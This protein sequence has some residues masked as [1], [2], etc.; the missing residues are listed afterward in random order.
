VS[1]HNII[2]NLLIL[3]SFILALMAFLKGHK[4]FLQLTILLGITS[5]EE[6]ISLYLIAKEIDFTW[7][8]HVYNIIEYSLLCLFFLHYIKNKVIKKLISVS[9]PV[10]ICISVSISFFTYKFE[11]FP[12]L[13][14][15]IEGLLLSVVCVYMLLN[16]E[17]EDNQ[18][19][20]KKHIFWI[21][22][23]IFVFFGS[24]FFYNG[25]YTRI[26]NIDP[27]KAMVLFSIINRPLNL[28]LYSFII[29]G[30]TC[31]LTSKKPII[32]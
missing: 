9:I 22:S 32:Q 21:C 25:I 7:L 31:L 24:T 30:I 10:F 18:S 28:L 20:F 26:L 2:Y 1:L 4:H 27:S 17:V 12:G 5:V 29:T 3:I 16:I 11:G 23:G 6:L 15:N 13:N 19:I 8:Y 14:I